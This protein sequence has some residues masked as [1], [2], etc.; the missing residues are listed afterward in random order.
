[1]GGETNEHYL[2]ILGR[3]EGM[4]EETRNTT[5][6][7]AEGMQR[8]EDRLEHRI[9]DHDHRLRAVEVN[10]ARI[11]ALT[12]TGGGVLVTAIVEAFKHLVK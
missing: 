4:L 7:L 10:A 11:G 9:D 6:K 3:I 2:R 1:M 8:I 12:G 5:A